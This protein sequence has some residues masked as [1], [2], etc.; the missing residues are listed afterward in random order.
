MRETPWKIICFGGSFFEHQIAD[1]AQRLAKLKYI[2]GV[3]IG[4]SCLGEGLDDP[5]LEPGWQALQEI[6]QVHSHCGL[7][8]EIYSLRQENYGHVLPLAIG[9]IGN[10]SQKLES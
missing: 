8:K 2:R 6:Q 9:F 7:P 3:I 5:R 1:K 4:A 10:I